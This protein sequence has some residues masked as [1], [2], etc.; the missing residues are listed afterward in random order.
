VKHAVIAL[1]ALHE[2]FEQDRLESAEKDFAVSQYVRALELMVKPGSKK[3]KGM[4]VDVALITCVLFVCFEVRKFFFKLL[5]IKL[6][7]DP[8]EAS[9]THD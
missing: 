1:G 4:N 9:F 6:R 2:T 5:D 3:E 7:W 8:A